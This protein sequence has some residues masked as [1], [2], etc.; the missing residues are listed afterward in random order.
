MLYS[1]DND[2]TKF[3][4]SYKFGI[5]LSQVPFYISRLCEN[6]IILIV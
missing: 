2:E 4:Y 1:I 5:F 3:T 6:L